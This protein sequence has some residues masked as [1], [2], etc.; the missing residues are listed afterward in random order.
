[1]KFIKPY[2]QLIL[3]SAIILI[4]YMIIYVTV[5]LVLSRHFDWILFVLCGIVVYFACL[6]VFH[7]ILKVNIHDR[8]KLVY[9]TIHNLKLTKEEKGIKINLAEDHIE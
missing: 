7:Y 2:Y 5:S 3:G 4:C 8:I 6:A 1:M 9:K